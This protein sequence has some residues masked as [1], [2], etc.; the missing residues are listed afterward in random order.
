MVPRLVHIDEFDQILSS[1]YPRQELIDLA[2]S[3]KMVAV[4]GTFSSGRNTIIQELVKLGGYRDLITDTTR[5]KRVNDGV[6]EQDG[7]EYYFRTEED[8]LDRLHAGKYLEAAVIHRQQVS[9][10]SEEE[11]QRA[12]DEDRIAIFD[13]EIAGAKRLKQLLPHITIAFV[14]PPSF[15][16][17][18]R[19]FTLRGMTDQ[20]EIHRRMQSAEKEIEFAL[21]HGEFHFVVND[22]LEIAVEETGE[23]CR[24][25]SLDSDQVTAA[26]ETAWKLLNEIKRE[27]Y[28]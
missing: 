11:L 4:I 15:E 3:I 19:R 28:S 13:A 16:E 5:P 21:E 2:G 8:F 10:I 9:G 27:L 18:A 12:K 26:K 17:W 23:I 7:V 6:M 22:N 1:Y 24:G 14:I 20:D 25:L